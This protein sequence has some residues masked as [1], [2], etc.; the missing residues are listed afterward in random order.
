[1]KDWRSASYADRLA[2]AADFVKATAKSRG[3]S[4]KSMDE[5]KTHALDLERQVSAAGEGGYADN[6]KVS[7]VAAACL[8]LID[9]N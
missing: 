4:F 2:T 5:V 6:Q 3:L 8:V 9:K 1:M 7:E